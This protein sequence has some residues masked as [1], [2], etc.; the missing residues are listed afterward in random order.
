MLVLLENILNNIDIILFIVGPLSHNGLESA[1]VN[2]GDNL[3]IW[4][5]FDHDKYYYKLKHTKHN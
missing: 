3:Y 2:G 5:G 4:L 1:Q